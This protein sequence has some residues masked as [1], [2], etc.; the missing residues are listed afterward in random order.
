MNDIPIFDSLTHPSL[1]GD[2]I[3]PRYPQKSKI[4]DLLIEMDQNNICNAFAVGMKGIGDYDEAK[5]SQYVI[6]KT[7]K[8]LPIAFF[9]VNEHDNLKSIVEKL[10]YLRNLK[11]IGI[12]LHPRI[13]DFNLLHPLLPVI[14]KAANDENMVVLF[15]TYFY[16]K[17][18]NVICNNIDNLLGLL[19]KIPN[20]KIILLH[21]GTVRLL[22]MMEIA[23]AFDNVLLDLSLT[24]CKYQGSS[25]DMDI[26]F[27]FKNFDRRICIGSDHPEFRMKE[28]R[29]RFNYFSNDIDIEKTKNI[30]FKNISTFF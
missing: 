19:M 11:Y 20:E 10:K 27:L 15:C 3:L 24:L 7:D 17:G 2:W 21:S 30:A 8:L 1:N 22:E 6:E 9:N 23:R 25:L 18:K 12:K 14:I 29:E 16:E 13:G 4:D 26:Q 5:Y 28:I